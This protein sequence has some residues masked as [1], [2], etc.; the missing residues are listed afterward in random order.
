MTT[1]VQP[2]LR[3]FIASWEGRV[4]T[5]AL[6]ILRQAEGYS[7]GLVGMSVRPS[8]RHVFFGF[9]ALKDS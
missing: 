1:P 8:V 5:A 7:L 6:I 3:W 9:F 2:P 4:A